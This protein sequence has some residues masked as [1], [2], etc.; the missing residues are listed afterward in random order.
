[1]TNHAGI[2]DR[3]ADARS[4]LAMAQTLQESGTGPHG[5]VHN[6]QLCVE[7]CTKAVITCFQVPGLTHNPGPELYGVILDHEA[8][9]RASVG[10]EMIRRLR[11]LAR[12]TEEIA[13]WHGRSTYSQPRSDG[14][15][16]SP[17]ALCTEERAVWALQLAE[18]SL[19]TAETFAAAWQA[20]T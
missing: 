18:R 7:Y 14:T 3:L 5:V 15:Y 4:Y 20:A 11:V 1:M 10:D 19:A 2:E 17:R 13:P 6:A 8:S 16:V 9:L 12:D